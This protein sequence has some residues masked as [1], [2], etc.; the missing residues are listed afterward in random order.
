MERYGRMARVFE[1]D[2]CVVI[3]R[4]MKKKTKVVLLCHY[5]SE[6][7]AEMVGRKHYFQELSPWIQE[8]LNC[9]K[10]KE[11]VEY[12]VVAPNYAS[13]TNLACNKDGIHFHFFH[14]SPTLLSELAAP[15]IKLFVKHLETFKIAERLANTLTGFKTPAKSAEKIIKT[16]NP[17]LIHLYGSENPDYAAPAIK[18]MKQYPVLLT[19]QG[20]VC[21]QTPSKMF[22][23]KMFYD[24]RV[25]Y[26]KILNNAVRY[27]TVS[28]SVSLGEFKNNKV[29][30]FG[31]CEKLYYVTAITKVPQLDATL[32]N[33]K[34]DLVYYARIDKNKGIED[35]IDVVDYLRRKGRSI[36]TLVIG[37]GSEA[38]VA[39]LKEMI[40][41]KELDD[42][43]EFAGFIEK[44][45][46][47]YKLAAQARMMVLPTHNDG[48][49][50]T[51]REAMFM[52]LPVISNNIGG[53]P[54][55]N[56]NRH[57]IHLVELGDKEGLA[58]GIC[59]VLDDEVYRNDLIC[60]SYLEAQEVYSPDAVYD[61][62]VSAYKD[63][64]RQ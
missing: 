42:L 54:R 60:Q 40:N 12:Y 22:L 43:I 1:N 64:V 18:L 53:I 31:N 32:A 25:R 19:V 55:F 10:N 30:Y 41:N 4:R 59:K 63:I 8:T 35:L 46:D 9:F 51:I 26:E 13:N 20:L 24:Y 62:I 3:D 15:F 6:E 50:N 21:L 14:Y 2:K 57:C 16:I 34:Y 11:D 33:K 17:D 23:E 28:R 27:I 48:L 61:Q 29:H 44:H 37:K 58:D 5:W 36:K 39:R 47:V 45:E 56:K 52:K 49:P 38:Y 7:M